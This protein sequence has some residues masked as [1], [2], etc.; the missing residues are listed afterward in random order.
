M[1]IQIA[2]QYEENEQYDKAYEEYKKIYD[3]NPKDMNV[4]ERLGHLSMMLGNKQEAADYYSKILEFDVT[5]SMVYEQLMDI[6]QDIDR[7]K[8][9]I[10]RGNLHSIE[11]KF[12]HAIN[13]FKKAL[14]NTQEEKDIITTRFVL[15]ALYAQTGNSTKAIDE[16][17]R[18]LDY[19]E[20]PSETYIN[21]AKLYIA[22]NAVSSA[23]NV[24]E[25]AIAKDID[26]ESIRETLADL[27]LKD[28]QAGKA[29]KLTQNELTKVKCML[30][31]G[32]D[33]KAYEILSANKEKY[34]T[35]A[36]YHSLLA[37]Y[38]FMKNKFDEALSE[39]EEF[40]KYEKN[41]PLTYQMRALIFENKKD[42]YNAHINWGKYNILR[43]NKDIAINEYL[44]A[45]QMRD[46]DLN[47]LSSLAVLLEENGD[48]N[49]AM[50]IYERIVKLEPNN[51]KALEK[52]ADFRNDIGDY[53]GE[54]DFLEMWYESDKRNY[55]LIKRLAKTYERLKNKPSAIEFYKKYL[56][57]TSVPDYETVKAHLAKL[58]NTEM[59]MQEEEGWLDKIMR[60]FNKE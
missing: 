15:A 33:D 11:H 48:K 8:Y 51:I 43:G 25:R 54:C 31:C 38:Y 9:Y 52:L 28:N 39:V 27:Y 6:Y 53:R 41:S 57:S 42:D 24:L 7:F 47:L 56:Q 45:Y 37:Q 17:L 21:L 14:A 36:K 49:H 32:D 22:E 35:N 5:N 16:Y 3:K 20:I 12:E 34:Q 2:E 46:D 55:D 40:D 30:D 60:F 50:E 26:S 19:S 58:E 23:I 29:L 10:H 44:N 1:S 13:D 4:L 18:L 59:E